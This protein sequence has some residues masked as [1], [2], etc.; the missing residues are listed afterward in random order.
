[1]KRFS[2]S[3]ETFRSGFYDHVELDLLSNPIQKL[4]SYYLDPKQVDRIT[5][6]NLKTIIDRRSSLR[7][8]FGWSFESEWH[9][10]KIMEECIEQVVPKYNYA[11]NLMVSDLRCSWLGFMPYNTFEQKTY[12]DLSSYALIMFNN[13]LIDFQCEVLNFIAN[14]KLFLQHAIL[15]N[16]AY[17]FD[18]FK[19]IRKNRDALAETYEFY[20]KAFDDVGAISSIPRD[21]LEEHIGCHFLY[22]PDLFFQLLS[23]S[24][25]KGEVYE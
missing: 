25:L 20:M 4:K 11:P 19:R 23:I 21:I 1:M 22:H 24:V 15:R 18:K 3:T 8:E 17:R 7:V 6:T 10:E 14:H 2:I 5:Q 9:Y 16:D 12:E 13:E